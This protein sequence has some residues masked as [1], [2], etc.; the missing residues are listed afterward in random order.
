M[1]HSIPMKPRQVIKE[2]EPSQ[3]II[4]DDFDKTDRSEIPLRKTQ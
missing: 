3:S 2:S 1:S 4:I